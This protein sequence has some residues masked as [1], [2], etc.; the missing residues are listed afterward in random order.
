MNRPAT[1]LLVLTAVLSSVTHAQRATGTAAPAPQ[2]DTAG[3]TATL[4]ALFA[5]AERNDMK[6]LD[7][8]YAGDSLT[9]V[10]GAGIN[11]GWTDYRDHHLAPEMKE[12][13]NFHYR[14]VDI[15]MHVSGN[16]AWAL[17]RYNLKGEMGTRTL[18]NVG[19][20]TAILERRGSGASARWVVRHTQTSSR[21][22][23]PSD[24]PAG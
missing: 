10:E 5:A 2:N 23:R 18:D 16:T 22:R 20:G 6:A 12:M 14:P 4:R 15:E 13:K 17:Y 1:V 19:R 21:A 8:L 9:V 24:P 11:R 7:T 3:A